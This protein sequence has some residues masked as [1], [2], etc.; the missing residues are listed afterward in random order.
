MMRDEIKEELRA[1][2]AEFD[3][4]IDG[5]P[6]AAYMD[7][8]VMGDWTLKD[9]LAHICRWEGELV[10]MLFQLR[11]GKSP[12][13]TRIEGMDQV[14][15]HNEKWH[16][17]DQDR[18]LDLVLSDFRGLRKQTLRRV[19]EFSEEELTDPDRFED[20]RGRPLS[21]WIA[22]DTYE[23]ER[24]HLAAVRAWRRTKK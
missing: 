10:T 12:S 4:A 14:D 15:R 2:R 16:R 18:E 21:E 1:S 8:G 5:L 24:E 20:L 9:I 6:E 17:E 23:H 19:E 3:E 7:S 22:V 11:Q 13:R